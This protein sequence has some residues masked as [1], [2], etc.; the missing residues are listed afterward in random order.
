MLFAQ[1]HIHVLKPVTIQWT[2]E[3]WEEAS[4]AVNDKELCAL[5]EAVAYRYLQRHPLTRLLVAGATTD[6]WGELGDK[7]PLLT[8]GLPPAGGRDV[9]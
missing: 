3:Q 9:L 4:A 2:N 7:A 5:L 1:Y 8:D 6:D